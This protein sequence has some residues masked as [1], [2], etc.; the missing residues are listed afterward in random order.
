MKAATGAV[1]VLLLMRRGKG[2]L[3]EGGGP[4]FAGTD[5]S[6]VPPGPRGWDRRAPMMALR[7]CNYIR[8]EEEV[9]SGAVPISFIYG[10]WSLDPRDL[11]QEILMISPTAVVLG[12][13][14]HCGHEGRM[15]SCQIMRDLN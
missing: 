15:Q 7:M 2:C 8:L 13:L 9:S 11:L 5:D 12:K 10:H 14:L 1:S 4:D 6:V 3:G